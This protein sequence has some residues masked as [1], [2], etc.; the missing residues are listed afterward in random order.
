MRN[1]LQSILSL[2]GHWVPTTSLVSSQFSFSILPPVI[3]QCIAIVSQD[4]GLGFLGHRRTKD[5]K[6]ICENIRS[7]RVVSP[8]KPFMETASFTPLPN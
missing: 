6:K 8:K 4:I 1:K 3:G 7:A 2:F 5:W